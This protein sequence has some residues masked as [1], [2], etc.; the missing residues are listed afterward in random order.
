MSL[1][2]QHL[3]TEANIQIALNQ[4]VQRAAAVLQ[5]DADK[6]LSVI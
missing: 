5:S 3:T 2:Q 1:L 6:T 4:S